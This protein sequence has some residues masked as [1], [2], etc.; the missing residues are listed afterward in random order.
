[1][2]RNKYLFIHW[3]IRTA[4]YVSPQCYLVSAPKTRYE[5]IDGQACSIDGH[6]CAFEYSTW[7]T[8]TENNKALWVKVNHERILALWGPNGPQCLWE[9]ENWLSTTSV[10][11][12]LHKLIFL[13]LEF[14]CYFKK[15]FW[16][17][18]RKVYFCR[19]KIK[20]FC[21]N[22]TSFVDDIEIP[23]K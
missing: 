10:I 20:F 19:R 4:F 18:R 6:D 9:T 16:L 2:T 11:T 17:Y 1:M 15:L 21:W 13:T 12:R 7:Q 14:L 22:S 8:W 23:P 3:L 5:P